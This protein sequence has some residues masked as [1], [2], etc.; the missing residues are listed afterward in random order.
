ME[1]GMVV[2]R[3]AVIALF[4]FCLQSSVEA[5]TLPDG[6]TNVS[7][8]DGVSG[9]PGAAVDALD[10]VHVAWADHP[11]SDAL[12][13]QEVYYARAVDGSFEAPR[14]LSE[15]VDGGSLP[16]EVYVAVSGSTVVVAWWANVRDDGKEF[17]T[18]FVARSTDGGESFAPAE[19]T[20]IR[21]RDG[22]AR[23]EGF[24]N[25][26]RLALALGPNDQIYLLA[27]IADLVQGFNVYFVRSLAS[28]GYSEPL[29]VSDY[30]FPVPRATSIALAVFE[31]G[32]IYASWTEGATEFYE[33][34]KV[35]RRAVSTDGGAS[36]SDPEG[37]SGALGAVGSAYTS[38]RTLLLLAQVK[39]TPSSRAVIKVARSTDGG[40]Q[41]K[42][43][44]IIAKAGGHSHLNQSSLAHNGA[45]IAVT[46]AEYS[47]RPTTPNGVYV[48]ISLDGGASFSA[49]RLVA[50]G[51]F[52][53]PPAATVDSEG[54]VGVV[55]TSDALYPTDREVVFMAV[56]L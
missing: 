42:N 20:T 47:S 36:F 35:I 6:A 9:H 45:V 19:Q 15:G 32:R 11:G 31:D 46:W 48:A 1:I 14:R 52:P 3:L 44:K 24:S 22:V 27:T 55:F 25:T 26:T 51:L 30:P 17:F 4:V 34:T 28:G 2:I 10:R 56:A 39:R 5:Q 53:D 8:S 21:F 40:R 13:E 41:F 29:R 54:R 49:P 33:E 23:K 7:K 12:D 16:R 37:V 50:P 43:R 38:G 18:A